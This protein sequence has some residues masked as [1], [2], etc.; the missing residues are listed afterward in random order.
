[1]LWGQNPEPFGCT[2]SDHVTL[3]LETL[4]WVPLVLGMKSTLCTG[5]VGTYLSSPPEP[6]PTPFHGSSLSSDVTLVKPFLYT[7]LK[8]TSSS[9]TLEYITMFYLCFLVELITM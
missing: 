4:Q 7:L 6:P 3:L 5:A 9:V 1:M 8:I 2:E